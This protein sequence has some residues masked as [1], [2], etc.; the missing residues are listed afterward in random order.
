MCCSV[1]NA[2]NQALM[3]TVYNTVIEHHIEPITAE[4][5]VISGLQGI[6]E[7]DKNF[8]LADGKEMI[9][10][11]YQGKSSGLWKKP[12]DK[13]DLKAWMDISSRLIETAKKKSVIVKD[14]DYLV[15]EKLISAAV[16]KL[17]DSSRFYPATYEDQTYNNKTS[18]LRFT[19]RMFGDIMYLRIANFND[20]MPSDIKKSLDN[21]TDIKGLILDLRGNGG[22]S[23]QTAIDIAKMFIDE[24]GIILSVRGRD[25]ATN[26]YTSNNPNAYNLPL[27]VLIDANTASS[28]EVLAAALQEQ[29][30]AKLVGTAS[31]GKG[32][33]QDTYSF[34]N[35]S[36]LALTSAYYFTPSGKKLEGI[37]LTPEYC[38]YKTLEN[39]Y[40]YIANSVCSKESREGNETDV[41]IAVS[42]LK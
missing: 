10:L 9:Y 1:A 22:G 15:P 40:D 39:N 36:K 23:L 41:E 25:E 8:T 13:N 27:A 42:V 3:T 24:G 7:V 4:S 38:T 34:E 19:E 37:G 16:K 5:L 12:E 21:R 14:N 33:I 29:A 17:N 35:G 32:S 18:K 11:Y 6:K 2:A 31:F 20:N 26:F 30:G 28:A